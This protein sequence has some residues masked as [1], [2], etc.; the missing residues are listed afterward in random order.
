MSSRNGAGR[1]HTITTNLAP[2]LSKDEVSAK[3]PQSD[4]DAPVSDEEKI[5]PTDSDERG[6]SALPPP[7]P[8]FPDGGRD[9]WRTVIAGT[10]I[11]CCSFGYSNAWGAVQ[12]H[13]A[14]NQLRHYKPSDLSWIGSAHLFI[15]FLGSFPNGRV[16]DMGYYRYQLGCGTVL[17]I[18]GLFTLSVSSKFYQFFL[19]YSVCMG[20]GLSCMFSVTTS[21][22]GSYFHKRRSLMVGVA[23]GGA[24]AGTVV[25]PIALNRLFDSV[26][27]E[28]AVQIVAAVIGASL[29]FANL[30]VVPRKLPRRDVQLL[31]LLKTFLRQP[32]SWLVYGGTASV[33]IALF[34]PLFLAQVYVESWGGSYVL[35]TYTLSFINATAVV[36]RVVAGLVADRYGVFNTQVPTAFSICVLVF[37]FIGP[38]S[39]ASTIIYD[40]L[41]GAAF[42][43]WVTLMPTS[44]MSLAEHPGEFGV[45]TGLGMVFVSIAVLIGTPVAGALI[46]ASGGEYW[47]ATV[48]GGCCA[49]VGTIIL[50]AGR[51][52]QLFKMSVEPH[53]TALAAKVVAEDID[54]KLSDNAGEATAVDH[55]AGIKHENT[56]P[57]F[58]NGG[59]HAWR[60]VVAGTCTLFATFGLS[61]SFGAMQAEFKRDLLSTYNTSQISWLGSS[62]MTF[63]FLCALPAGRL[64]DQGYFR[65][66]LAV[67]SLLFTF[68]VFMLSLSTEYYQVFLSYSVGCGVGLGLVFAPSVSCV[69]SYFSTKRTLMCGICAAGPAAAGCMFPATLNH[70]FPRLGFASTMRIVG[71]ICGFLLLLANTLVVPR[72]LP[73]R[74]VPVLK[75]VA[76]F[77]R[78]PM[79]WLVGLGSLCCMV[80]V[81]VP[82][83]LFQVFAIANKADAVVINYGIAIMNA[84]AV[85]SRVLAGIIADKYGVFNAAVPMTFAIG[86]LCFA[87]LGATS[88]AGAIVFDILFGLASGGWITISAPIFMVLAESVSEIGVRA[89]VGFIFVAVGVLLGSP[90]AGQIL[91]A[92]DGK[93]WAPCTYSGIVAILGSALLLVARM[94]LARARGTWKV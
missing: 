34:V 20:L 71:A 55:E 58:P 61:I 44:F 36:T 11:L 46:T 30:L 23:A 27:Y 81:F 51:Q 5:A 49:L 21:C 88:T 29:L 80:S 16:F 6:P 85:V 87:M 38:R 56:P 3:S 91:I 14:R 31:Q 8:I 89:G 77:Y 7:P 26:G 13:L 50:I 70:L 24:A 53:T 92:A 94:R 40:L 18:V 66:Q 65:Q 32:Q 67:G 4:E 47:A 17:W 59:M 93:Y 19:S 90:M 79:T 75:L 33:M 83:F 74:N 64:F 72:K 69:A 45:R 39:T 73:R 57:A 9:A 82:M 62:M 25:F 48:W 22:I 76:K 28:R 10:I 12:A 41:Y 54:D 37:A 52:T 15:G 1:P 63:A 43:C 86:V 68:S 60:T 78:D 35:R 2:K 42:G 84:S